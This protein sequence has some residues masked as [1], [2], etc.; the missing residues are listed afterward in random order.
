M[1]LLQLPIWMSIYYLYMYHLPIYLWWLEYAW[2]VGSGTIRCSLVGID[3]VL[4]EEV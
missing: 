1:T 2:P 4:L 3:V